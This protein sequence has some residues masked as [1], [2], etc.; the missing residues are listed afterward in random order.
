QPMRAAVARARAR[1]GQLID[2]MSVAA[3]GDPFQPVADAGRRSVKQVVARYR[4]DGRLA[5]DD[6]IAWL[7]V[8]LG[9]LRVRDDAWARMDPAYN[10]EHRRLWTDLVWRLPA[11]LAAPPAALLAFT[12][13]QAGDGALASIAIE[14]ALAADPEYSMALLIADALHAG[15]PP[16]AARLPMTPKQVAA[17]YSRRR[18][19]RAEQLQRT[20]GQKQGSREAGGGEPDRRKPGVAALGRGG[21][22]AKEPG[23]RGPGGGALGSGGP[24][25]RALRRWEPDQRRAS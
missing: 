25:G 4:Q 3:G 19:A 12:A 6:E 2:L 8:V 10:D 14:R 23:R 5:D 17:S 20:A 9:D 13:W 22:G 16:S 15:L 21:P 1:A 7:G 18:Q 24:G 11:D